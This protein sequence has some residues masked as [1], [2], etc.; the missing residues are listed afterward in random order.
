MAQHMQHRIPGYVEYVIR[1]YTQERTQ[2]A[3]DMDM[4]TMTSWVWVKWQNHQ[5]KIPCEKDDQI[6]DMEEIKS[7]I[8]QINLLK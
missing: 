2:A 5:F 3:L 1:K 8:T 4:E 6:V 7:V